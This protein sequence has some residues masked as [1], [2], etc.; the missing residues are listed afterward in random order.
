MNPK[1][2]LSYGSS[3]DNYVEAVLRC[4][5]IP[6]AKYL[7]EPDTNYDGLILSGGGD[8]EPSYFGEEMDG[9]RNIDP[10]RDRCEF[11]L[12]KAYIELG[13]PVLGICR[14][15]QVLNVYFGGSLYQDLSNAGNHSSFASHDLVHPVCAAEGSVLESLFGSQFVTNSAHHQAIKELGKGLKA[16]LWSC[17]DGAVEGIEHESLPIIGVQWHPE[18]M[19]FGKRRVD[20]ADGAAI[21]R[22]F[23]DLCSG[24]K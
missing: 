3:C 10:D 4:G 13:K 1:I 17:H 7:P 23:M 9:S 14:G 5:G 21:F 24:R 2:L 15:H 6:T 8:I 11:A 19:C 18:R 16:T 22:Y 12:V 20:T